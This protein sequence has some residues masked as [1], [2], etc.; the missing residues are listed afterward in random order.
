MKGF[1]GSKQVSSAD[2]LKNLL[3][4]LSPDR[5][6][7]YFVRLPHK[8]SGICLNLPEKFF[9]GF[10]GQMFNEKLELRWK[11]QGNSYNVLLL[12]QEIVESD[13]FEK[14]EVDWRIS[15]RTAYWYV[16]SENKQLKQPAQFPKEFLFLDIDGNSIKPEDIKIGQRYFQDKITGTVHFVALTINPNHD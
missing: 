13:E 6:N 11:K 8:V 12:S 4:E 5:Q 7:Y 3:G 15:D 14:I 16:T 10:E 1:V 9:P 2:E